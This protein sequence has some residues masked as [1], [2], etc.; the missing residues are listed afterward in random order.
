MPNDSLTSREVAARFGVHLVTVDRWLR[1]GLLPGASKRGH[2][3]QIPAESLAEFTPPARGP[4]PAADRRRL[5]EFAAGMV[6]DYP[7]LLDYPDG[8]GGEPG[9]DFFSLAGILASQAGVNRERARQAL[10]KA[11]RRA[12]N[13]HK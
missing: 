6:E 8:W 9:D 4:K 1:D 7:G 11:I 5:G 12:R 3:W 13:P 10:A 2:D